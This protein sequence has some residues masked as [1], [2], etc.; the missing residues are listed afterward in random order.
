MPDKTISVFG[1]IMAGGVG[2]RFWPRSREKNPKQLISILGNETMIQQ[3]FNR[4]KKIIPN[5]NNFIIT[6]KL[7]RSQIIKQLPE[8]PQ[9]NIISEPIGRNTAPCIG[10]AAL[11][12]HRLNPEGVMVVVPADHIIK[13]VDEFNT[14]IE[15]AVDVASKTSALV[16]IG[17]KPNRP[18]TGYGYI[19]FDEKVVKT[20]NHHTSY[21]VKAFA[22]KPNIETA[23]KFLESGEFLWNSGMFVWRCDAILNEIKKSLPELYNFLDSLKD[24]IGTNLMDSKISDIY[25]KIKSISIDH[26]VM[27]KSENVLV[28]KGN[29]GW[30][31][32]GSWDEVVRLS[33]KDEN[34]NT[35]QGN[36]VM[37]DTKNSFLYSSNKIIA[38]VGVEDLIVINTDDAILIC[39][40]NESQ[41]VKKIVDH[42][43]I[44][45][46]NE[47]L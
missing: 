13:D 16:T 2:S 28:F 4:L 6:N 25:S 43:R 12:I 19:Q 27:E 1:V 38:T 26:G 30:N 47:Y 40:K 33:E 15:S 37:I 5:R 45:Q 44:K 18:D 24:S 46:M 22:E 29:F 36:I 32:V 10:L 20:K 42:L 39:K 35:V 21:K 34:G 8:V 7:Q 23:Q 3:T 31:D 11:F 41:N 14:V 9:E 17:I